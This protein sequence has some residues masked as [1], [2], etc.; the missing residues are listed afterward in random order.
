MLTDS[1]IRRSVGHEAFRRGAAYASEGRVS[2]IAYSRT[3][4]QFDATVIGSGGRQYETVAVYDAGSARWWGECSCPVGADCKHVAAVLI[5]ARD[6]Q[7]GSPVTGAAH[8][9]DWE[10]ALADLVQ[11]ATPSGQSAG[12]PLGLQ[13]DVERTPAD[14]GSAVPPPSI[15]LRP[16]VMGAKGRWIRTGVSWRLLQYDYYGQHDP[17]QAAAL[18]ALYRAHQ[19]A[20]DSLAYYGYGDTPVLLEEVGPA[21]WPAL[22]QV[23]D[24]GVTLVSTRGGPV[25]VAGEPGSLAVDLRRDGDADPDADLL[26]EPVVD[27]RSDVRVPTE[28]VRLIGSPP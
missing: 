26:I 27:L 4:G 17:A 13:F 16:V 21:L 1:V 18:R 22:Q 2:D 10:A 28:A 23:V 12:T 19:A 11:P 15:R 14:R 7:D 9:P 20:D 5:A 3:R 24:E 6:A 25:R 8:V